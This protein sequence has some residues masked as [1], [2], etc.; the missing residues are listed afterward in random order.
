MTPQEKLQLAQRSYAALSDLDP[1]A[2]IRFHTPDCEIRMTPS[3]AA[4]F[5]ERFIGHDGLRSM[6]HEFSENTSSLKI[7]ILE[8]KTATD[9]MLLIKQR[10]SVTSAVVGV[11]VSLDAWQEMEFRDGLIL[12]F[13]NFEEPPPGWDKAEPL[14]L[15]GLEG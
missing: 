9:G 13:T 5:G 4:V 15:S 6:V 14:S 11:G 8:A 10:L 3:V 1:D 2:F 7:E 12:G